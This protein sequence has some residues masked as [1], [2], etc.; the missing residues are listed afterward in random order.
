MPVPEPPVNPHP[1][2]PPSTAPRPRVYDVFINGFTYNLA[3]NN[4][5]T[6]TLT[7]RTNTAVQASPRRVR[8]SVMEKDGTYTITQ[9]PS[10]DS[11]SS[12]FKFFIATSAG[13]SVVVRRLFSTT[14][15]L[16]DPVWQAGNIL[17]IPAV[18]QGRD[19]E[20]SANP[21]GTPMVLCI[22]E[23]V[24]TILMPRSDVA[25]ALEL[26]VT[27]PHSIPRGNIP[28]DVIYAVQRYRETNSM[29]YRLGWGRTASRVTREGEHEYATE[30]FDIGIFVHELERQVRGD[31]DEW[32]IFDKEIGEEAGSQELGDWEE[33]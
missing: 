18:F 21:D 30:A 27:H 33:V 8:L 7:R 31:A 9:V 12:N 17:Y 22:D 25:P 3:D 24:S 13:D 29:A 28:S 26:P 4:I 2:F 20:T 15:L 19:L 16:H 5:Y 23:T 32:D 10:P 6:Y 1:I 11:T 14:A